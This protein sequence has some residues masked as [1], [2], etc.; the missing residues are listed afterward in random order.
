[1]KT[2]LL[3]LLT[4]LTIQ[5]QERARVELL[6]GVVVEYK[7]AAP[8]APLASQWM[9]V[10]RNPQP[11][12]NST[13]EYLT[14]TT[15]VTNGT[16][17]IDWTIVNKLQQQKDDEEAARVASVALE[18]KRQAILNQVTWLRE[19]ADEADATTVASG[20]SLA[21]LNALLKNMA[22]FYR[23]FANKIEVDSAP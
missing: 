21:V 2:F 17:V 22:Q 20:N 10:I 15:T 3:L 4:S 9:P 7:G 23:G 16:V 8:V 18:S 19:R 11:V 6:S 13:N 12:Y 1:M 14:Q 5:A